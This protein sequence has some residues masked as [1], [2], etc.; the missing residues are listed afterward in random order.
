MMSLCSECENYRKTKS[1]DYCRVSKWDRFKYL[2][3]IKKQLK[4]GDVELS[5]KDY[6][7]L[8]EL[9]KYSRAR[10]LRGEVG[11]EKVIEEIDKYIEDYWDWMGAVNK[12]ENKQEVDLCVGKVNYDN[13][14]EMYEEREGFIKKYLGRR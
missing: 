7:C 6:R 8:N 10:I 1:D 2:K 12:T 11:K 4:N 14:C 5:E 9:F 3:K 13:E